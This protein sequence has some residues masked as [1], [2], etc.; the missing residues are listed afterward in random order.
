MRHRTHALPWFVPLAF[1]L[2]SAGA[3][4]GQFSADRG[5]TGD[6]TLLTG[7][8]APDAGAVRKIFVVLIRRPEAPLAMESRLLDE[9]GGIRRTR[10]SFARDPGERVP[11]LWYQ[12]VQHSGP[13]P[14]VIFLHGTGGN[15]ESMRT[16]LETY[17]RAGFAAI[18]IDAPH[19]GERSTAGKGS[20][21]YQQAILKAWREPGRAHPFFYDTVWDVMRLLDLLQ[22]R[23]D[24]DPKRIGLAGYSKGGIETYLAAAIDRRIA[25]AVPYIGVQSFS[26][27]LA[28]NAW[29]SRISTIQ[30]AVDAA[31]KESGADVVDARFVREFYRRV[32]P[33]IDGLFDGPQMLP[34]IAPRPLLVINGDSD[35]RTPLAGVEDCLAAARKKYVEAGLAERIE[36]IAQKDTGH[37]VTAEAHAAGLAWFRR[38]L[39][40]EPPPT[41]PS[42]R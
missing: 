1:L 14:A 31:A 9:S 27:A 5:Y 23:D 18:A 32:A 15:K 10:F 13:R 37:K 2:A 16:S 20:A 8:M 21:D 7:P 4:T 24:I 19:H 11:G 3:Q 35:P 30:T 22:E 25:V 33:G 39:K 34:L 42:A 6:L 29:Q 38:W 17:A 26:W 28:N 40:P 36:F 12:P 41:D